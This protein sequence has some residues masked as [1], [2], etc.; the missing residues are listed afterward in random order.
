MSQFEQI[1]TVGS[2][3]SVN[4]S[5]RYEFAAVKQAVRE[6]GTMPPPRPASRQYLRIYSPVGTCSG[7]L[8]I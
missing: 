4:G 5:E 7:M 1:E 2:T 3:I 6:A 8:A